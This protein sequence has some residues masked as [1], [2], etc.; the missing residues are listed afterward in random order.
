[1]KSQIQNIF[2]GEFILADSYRERVVK[3]YDLPATDLSPSVERELKSYLGS[4]RELD[5]RGAEATIF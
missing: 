2:F 1:L 3:L 4:N 5:S